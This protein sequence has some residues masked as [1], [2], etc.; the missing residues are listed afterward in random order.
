MILNMVTNSLWN[1]H[2]DVRQTI[3]ENP[4]ENTIWIPLVEG[5]HWCIDSVEPASPETWM[6]WLRTDPA[7]SFV[8]NALTENELW[9]RIAECKQYDN[10]QWKDV[11]IQLYQNGAWQELGA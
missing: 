3:P 5:I 6:V 2:V 4:A 7:G 11:P 10:G 1:C 9:I 8:F